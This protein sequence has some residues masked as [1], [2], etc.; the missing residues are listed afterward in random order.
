MVHLATSVVLV[1]TCMGKGVGREVGRHVLD[2]AQPSAHTYTHA[3]AC[4]HTHT[5]THTHVRAQAYTH[6]YTY[7]VLVPGS[8]WQ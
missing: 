1:H 8:A 6:T 3:R 4:M 2:R 5:H 7:I